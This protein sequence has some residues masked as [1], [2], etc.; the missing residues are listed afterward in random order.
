MESA[1]LRT[2]KQQAAP[3]PSS[4]EASYI[5]QPAQAQTTKPSHEANSA[6]TTTST[7]P[8]KIPSEYDSIFDAFRRDTPEHQWSDFYK[9]M[10]TVPLLPFRIAN[11][12]LWLFVCYFSVLAIGPKLPTKTTKNNKEGGEKKRGKEEEN[13][14]DSS[15]NISK[16]QSF[17]SS[18]PLVAK[19]QLSPFELLSPTRQHLIT[20]IGKL[21][22]RAVLLGFGFYSITIIDE[23]GYDPKEAQKYTILSNH[24][25]MIDILL[26]MSFAMPSF[27]AKEAVAKLP[28][29]G[30]IATVMQCIYV[31]RLSG[32]AGNVT[33]KIIER[34]RL[35]AHIHDDPE[36]KDVTIAPLLIFPE[37]T[38]ANGRHI[39]PFR[40]GAFVSGCPVSVYFIRY[41]YKHF[42]VAWDT[43]HGGWFLIRL[44][45]ELYNRAEIYRMKPYY[46]SEAEKKDAKLYAANVAAHFVK[47]GNFFASEAS[48]KDKLVYH[49]L[50]RKEKLPAWVGQ[51]ANDGKSS[52]AV[53]AH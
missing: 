28:F 43:I 32:G 37:G 16:R 25:S 19:H 45:T 10:I 38:T 3:N 15:A 53:A 5:S 2:R 17:S 36:N 7:T 4:S 39:L 33:E 31:D 51:P 27:V 13:E 46:P 8:I 49:A 20:F 50:V 41:P 1:G 44:L 35:L 48:Y 9:L 34:Q 18:D 11:L 47:R 14:A 6:N 30:R 21:C 42:C 52:A 29:I 22:A 23:L 24:V 12:F 26:W 40:S